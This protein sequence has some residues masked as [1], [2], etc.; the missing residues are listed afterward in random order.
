MLAIPVEREKERKK[1]TGG[2]KGE[3]G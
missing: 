1:E 3:A 2:R